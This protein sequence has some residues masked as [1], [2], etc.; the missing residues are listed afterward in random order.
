MPT[1]Y[2]AAVLTTSDKYAKEGAEDKCGKI[3]LELLKGR[4]FEVIK[5]EVVP[6]EPEIIKEKLIHYCDVLKADLVLTN[7]GTGFTPRD[8]TPEATK[9]VIEREVPGISS[10]LSALRVSRLT[11]ILFS[12]A[13]FRSR[14][15]TD[16]SSPLVVKE[17]SSIPSTSLVNDLIRLTI[18]FRTKG[19][20]PVN[21]IFFMPSPAKTRANLIISSKF[22]S[23]L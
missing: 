8:F 4:P 23:R 21:R 5:Y 16:R 9:E 20:P 22:R 19:S 2:R 6:D 12:P 15:Y 18:P 7:G 1:V 13:S 10:N 11:F 17:T 3:I 14:A